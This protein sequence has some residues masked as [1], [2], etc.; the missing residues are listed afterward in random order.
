MFKSRWLY[1][2]SKYIFSF[3][4]HLNSKSNI[5]PTISTFRGQVILFPTFFILSAFTRRDQSFG[6]M[7]R[8]RSWAGKVSLENL[9]PKSKEFVKD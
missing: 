7:A 8:S 2:F 5:T 1:E 4:A 9:V 3:S 6:E